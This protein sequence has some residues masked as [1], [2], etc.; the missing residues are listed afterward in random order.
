MINTG[1][2][3]VISRIMLEVT[4]ITYTLHF[5]RE[6]GCWQL[7]QGFGRV[8]WQGYDGTIGALRALG[9]LLGGPQVTQ[10]PA[11]AHEAAVGPGPEDAYLDL[12]GSM[13]N[14]LQ[15]E[16]CMVPGRAGSQRYPFV[17][18]QG[19]YSLGE[20]SYRFR[21]P[22]GMPFLDSSSLAAAESRPV[23]NGAD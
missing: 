9:L 1:S 6:R 16:V 10:T 22:A 17:L 12:G 3:A 2:L 14:P 23:R 11:G 20:I 18:F 4:G 5:D 19:V 7:R 15:A 13:S 21:A 8:C